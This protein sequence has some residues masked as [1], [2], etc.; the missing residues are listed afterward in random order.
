[1]RPRPWGATAELAGRDRDTGVIIGDLDLSRAA[2]DR[3]YVRQIRGFLVGTDPRTGQ[4]RAWVVASPIVRV[5][6]PLAVEP[7]VI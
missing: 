6:R 2:V 1:M 3:D 7:A 5:L 4:L